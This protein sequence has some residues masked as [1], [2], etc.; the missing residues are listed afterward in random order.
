M[1]SLA[2]PHKDHARTRLPM[3]G[4]APR[5]ATPHPPPRYGNHYRNPGL[6]R[7]SASL[8]SAFSCALD[9]AAFA[10]SRT[11]QSPALGNE[12]IY[13][14]QDTR[15]KK[16][17]AKTRLPSDKHSK[18]AALGKGPSAAVLK[19]TA[20]SLC[21]GLRSALGKDLF[22]ECILWTL[23]KVYFYFFNFGNQTFCGMFLHYVDLH[24]SFWDNYNRVF[25][26]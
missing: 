16:L 22:T 26:R 2:C 10:E 17:S 7:V 24:I 6:C 15:H 3:R 1:D 4:S 19:L 13:R 18:K 23:G 9:K 12:L 11:R 5:L 21:R 20:V 25:N 8:P 14:V